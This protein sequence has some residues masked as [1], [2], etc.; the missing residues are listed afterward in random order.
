MK[1]TTLTIGVVSDIY[2]A[3]RTEDG[4]AFT[5]EVYRVVAEDRDGNRWVHQSRFAG[6]KVIFHEEEGY[7]AFRDIRPQAL[8]AAEAL[9][10]KVKAARAINLQY[11][12]EDRPA[13]GSK[14]YEAYGQAN[15]V[16][17]EKAQ[18]YD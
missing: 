7:N 17:Y 15:D 6:C 10:A 2:E 16:A 14:A 9:C 18:T 12:S 8:A 4:E 11:W 5:A 13:Y 1:T 3:G